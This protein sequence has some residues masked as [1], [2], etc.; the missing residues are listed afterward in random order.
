MKRKIIA[1]LVL[2]IVCLNT[3]AQNLSSSE[4]YLQ[5]KKIKNTASV[6][7]IAAHPDDENN[8]LLP[9]LA[10]EKLYRT[11]YLSLTR[12][13]GGQNLIGNEQGIELGMI[14]TQELL[15][16]RKID[17][18]EQY[19]ST[20]Y[21]FGFS[22]NAKEALSIWD[23]EKVLSDVVWVIRKFQPDIIITRFPGDARAGHGHHAASSI[24]ANEAFYAAA[25]ST[26]FPEQFRYGVRPWQAKR[27]L[28]NSFN[29]DGNNTTNNNQIKLD[30]GVY[31]ALLG[32][33]YGEIGGEARSMHKSQGE[34]RPRRKGSIMEYFTSTGGDTAKNDL[35]DG[36]ITDWNKDSNG[37]EINE[38]IDKIIANYNVEHPENSVKPLVELYKKVHQLWPTRATWL[39]KKLDEIQDLIINCSGLFAEATTQD[40]FALKG[41]TVNVSCF[42]NN[43]NASNVTFKGV[44]IQG[45]TLD[46]TKALEKNA[47]QTYNLKVEILQPL[48]ETQTQPYWLQLPQTIGNFT[49]AEQNLVGRAWNEALLSATFTIRV[50]DVD[51]YVTKPV[52]YK[53]VD[54]VKGEVTQPFVM[55]P[56]VSISVS[57]HVTLL[58]LL[59][60]NKIINTD[61]FFINY[62]SNFSGKNIPVNLYVLQDTIKTVF[63]NKL[64]DFEKNKS[65]RI[66]IPVK[67]FYNSLKGNA[68]E[69]AMRFKVNGKDYV[70]NQYFA[71]IQYN[72]IP[73]IHY[74]FKDK[75]KF[76]NDEVK[77]VGK[78]IGYIQGPG[79]R[80]PD[81]VKQM[82][83]DLKFLN[84]GDIKIE[85]LKQFDAIIIGI[86]AYNIYE[87]LTDKNDVLNEYV[88]NGGNLIVQ[89]IKSNQVGL[90]KIK[91]GPYPFTINTGSRVTEED[92][93]VNFLLPE[94][95]VL[96]YPNKI[97]SK[98]FENWVQERSTYQADQIDAHFQM[99][100]GM[101]D[102]G[103]K[104]SNGSLLIAPY[105]KGN[106]AYVSL[107][108][109]RQLPAGV[110][111]SYRLLANLIALPKH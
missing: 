47:N 55:M 45:H 3:S 51:F 32:E 56:H 4:I 60:K 54:P 58:N 19:F 44:Y 94:H 26:K 75:I 79:D 43:R 99:P 22:K 82:G 74:F 41:D 96:N 25:D 61:T 67:K 1:Y 7:Y 33:S 86:R 15:A 52:Q 39:N 104:E 63:E 17:G 28:W 77:T 109:F 111:G 81:A 29:F 73:N 18:C 80:V 110:P 8:G 46:T 13:D 88:N 84:E 101:H 78:K 107:V 2:V 9:Y 59:P 38:A 105:G 87:W 97:T 11:A 48:E 40:E 57:P 35:M 49:V 76:V 62:Q 21:E 108:L 85:D 71:T 69:V 106:I 93:K 95:P 30:A 50:E 5:L 90:K 100:L 24:I 6:L 98:D 68:I 12:G 91:I 31:N 92:A 42:V 14:R 65:D 66:A 53:Y 20:A 16:A 89:Y 103:E 64:M 102:T 36:I 27:I 37:K 70:Y 83:Y 72:H 10:K 34:G 23:K